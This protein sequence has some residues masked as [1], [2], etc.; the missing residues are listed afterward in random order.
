LTNL[1][2]KGRTKI[3]RVNMKIDAIIRHCFTGIALAG[4]LAPGAAAQSSSVG[5]TDQQADQHDLNKERHDR[6]QDQR[7]INHD[8]RDLNQDRRDRNADN[9]DISGIGDSSPNVERM[10]AIVRT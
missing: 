7:D 2:Q 1:G 3:R 4:M 5:P 6:N 9:R 10:A 8:R